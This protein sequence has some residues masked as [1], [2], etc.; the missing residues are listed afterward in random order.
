MLY[1]AYGSNMNWNQIKERCQSAGFVCIARMP[2]FRFDFTRKSN[3]RGCGVMDIVKDENGHVWGVVFQI[4]EYD[5]GQLNKSEGYQ[6]GRTK[7]AY[8][9]LEKIVYQNGEDEK[10]ITV[11]TYEVAK[12]APDTIPPNKKY[13]GLILEGARNW[14]LPEDYIEKLSKVEVVDGT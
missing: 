7:N 13:M 10:P 9:R 5:L 12:K 3:D 14:N 4:D 1:F 2:G 11:F 6:P 8:Q